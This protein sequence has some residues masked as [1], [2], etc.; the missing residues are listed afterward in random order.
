MKTI[1]E[2]LGEGDQLALVT[3]ESHPH[4]IQELGPVDDKSKGKILEKVITFSDDN[5][6]LL[7][8]RYLFFIKD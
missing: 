4:V 8:M 6:C 7:C 3:F 5:F 1:T 2:S